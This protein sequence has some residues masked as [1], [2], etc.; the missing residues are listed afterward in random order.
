MTI[1]TVL[2]CV[3]A[4]LAS[5]QTNTWQAG[6]IMDDAV[7]ANSRSLS[8]AQIQ[9]F[10]NSKVTSCDTAGSQP[11]EYGGGTRSQWAQAKYGQSTF[12]CLKDYSEGGRSAAQ[13]IFD[14]AQQYQI[15]PQVLLVLLQKEQG[16]VTDTWPLNIQ[17]RSAT[18]VQTPHPAI[19]NITD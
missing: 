10:L 1:V 12:T 14:S 2:V 17:Y 11:S 6:R 9:L 3:T 18:A 15:N 19:V 16:L 8:A 13:I 7:F 4:P 5:A